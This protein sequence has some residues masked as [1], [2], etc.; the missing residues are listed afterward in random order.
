[1]LSYSVLREIQKKEVDSAAVARVE[2]DF[3]KS[4]SGFLEEKKQKAMESG[5]LLS[6][7]EYENIKRIVSAIQSR[8]EE[9]IVLMAV[10]GES[11]SEGLSTEEAELLADLCKRIAECRDTVSGIWMGK[12]SGPSLKKVRILKDIEAYTG[13]DKNIY[14]PYRSGDEPSLPQPE[15]QWLLKSRMAEVL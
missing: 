4:V 10:R 12:E 3:Y 9:K 5:S 6:I 14:G 2:P 1:M 7:K 15:A 11:E 13:V 8:R